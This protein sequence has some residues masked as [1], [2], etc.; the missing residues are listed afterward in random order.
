[1][2]PIHFIPAGRDW[3]MS[4]VCMSSVHYT[5][6][7]RLSYVSHTLYVYRQRLTYVSH[8]WCLGAETVIC[9]LCTMPVGRDCCMSYVCMS[10]MHCVCRQ[11]IVFIQYSNGPTL[12]LQA[13][14]RVLAFEKSFMFWSAYRPLETIAAAILGLDEEQNGGCVWLLWWYRK[15]FLT[16]VT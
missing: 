11:K 6:M 1:M 4:Y 2:S 8:A 12:L 5:C 3:C 14:N 7:Q 16:V 13:E 10:P 15:V 9:L